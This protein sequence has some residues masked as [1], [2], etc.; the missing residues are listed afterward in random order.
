[1]FPLGPTEFLSARN[2]RRPEDQDQ[3]QGDGQ[4]HFGQAR[5]CEGK[6]IAKVDRVLDAT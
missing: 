5:H 2:A 1:M 6:E 4:A 3:D